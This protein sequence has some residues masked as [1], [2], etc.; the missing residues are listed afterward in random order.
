MFVVT[1]ER[2]RSD[3]FYKVHAIFDTKSEAEEYIKS[4]CDGRLNCMQKNYRRTCYN[5]Y[6]W[7]NET[8]FGSAKDYRIAEGARNIERI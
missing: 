8:Q 7:I 6:F 1:E 3:D 2:T 4:V 5:Y